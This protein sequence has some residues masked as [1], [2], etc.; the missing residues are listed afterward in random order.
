MAKIQEKIFIIQNYE[1]HANTLRN[2]NSKKITESIGMMFKLKNMNISNLIF[3]YKTIV[4][5]TIQIK[6]NKYE[7]ILCPICKNF[8]IIYDSGS[9]SYICTKCFNNFTGTI[10]DQAKESYKNISNNKYQ[11][12]TYCKDYL[13]MFQMKKN[14][15]IPKSL[16]C[17]IKKCMSY[18]GYKSEALTYDELRQML[19]II[20]RTKK[21]KSTVYKNTSYIMSMLK[22]TQNTILLTKE[23]ENVVNNL[24]M[25][26]E[27]YLDRKNIKPNY[28]FYFYKILELTDFI[29]EKKYLNYFK[30]SKNRNNIEKLNI[31]WELVCNHFNL[32]YIH[33]YR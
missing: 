5:F 11:R 7:R 31:Q 33:T 17:D 27:K 24:F 15:H 28:G 13:K 20:N 21:Y 2:E 14:I 26:I 9:T 10:Y 19:G 4:P 32:R 25:E 8:D 30:L 6:K 12:I 3:E 22:K 29:K 23:Q 18:M 16:I 1:K